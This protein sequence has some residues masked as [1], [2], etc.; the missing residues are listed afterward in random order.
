M[1]RTSW[2]AL[3]SLFFLVACQPQSKQTITIIDGDQIHHVITTE[4]VPTSL[5]SQAGIH[6]TTND[7]VLLNGKPVALNQPMPTAQTYTLQVQR[8]VALTVNGKIIRTT[9]QTV[10]EA[11]SQAGAQL[12][13]SDQI[14][15]PI[16]TPI[17]GPM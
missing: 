1:H 3:L 5:L 12:Y 11:L 13:A 4:R 9:A 7:I 16:H 15:P 10:G 8:A 2:L 17:T 14:S 6:L